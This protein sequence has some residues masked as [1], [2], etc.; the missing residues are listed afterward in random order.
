MEAQYASCLEGA[1]QLRETLEYDWDEAYR[2]QHYHLC[3]DLD[4]IG[5]DVPR[6]HL[7]VRT[8]AEV[9]VGLGLG[10]GL[11]LGFMSRA[12]PYARRAAGAPGSR[13]EP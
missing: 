10:L 1:R 2:K 13:H 11:G 4:V 9:G 12:R 8:E 6:T 5:E 7:M 3:S